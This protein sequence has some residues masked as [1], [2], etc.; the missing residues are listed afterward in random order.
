MHDVLANVQAKKLQKNEGKM[1][2]LM[3]HFSPLFYVRCM[4]CMNKN[5]ETCNIELGSAAMSMYT[6]FF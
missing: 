5:L 1:P 3:Q 4:S 6:Q 2:A